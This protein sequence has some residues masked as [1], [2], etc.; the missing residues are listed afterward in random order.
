LRQKGSKSRE[1][2]IGNNVNNV[3]IQIQEDNFVN[4]PESQE[5]QDWRQIE[6]SQTFSKLGN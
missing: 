3:K 5:I 6:I 2:N 4:M 1:R